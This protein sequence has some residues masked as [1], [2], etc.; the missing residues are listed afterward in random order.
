MGRHLPLAAL[1]EAMGADQG[2][3]AALFSSEGSSL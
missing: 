2:V 3:V 1:L